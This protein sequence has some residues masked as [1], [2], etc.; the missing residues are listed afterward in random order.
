LETKQDLSSITDKTRKI[1]WGRSGNRCAI[2]K[3][4]LIIGA[5][6]KDSEAIVGDECHIV[7]H[8]LNGPRFDPTYPNDKLDSYDNLILLCRVHHKMIDDQSIAYTAD[9]LHQMKNDHEVM[10][11]DKL[12]DKQKIKPL[13][14][15]RIKKNIPNYL[16]RLTTGRQIIDIISGTY[17]FSI[18]HD[19]LISQDEVDIV[20]SFLQEVSDC[21]DLFDDL[22]PNARVNFAF[23]F[24]QMLNELEGKGFVAFGG[25]EVQL[26]EG[27]NQDEPSKWP[28]A[29]VHVL[30]NDN[31]AIIRPSKE[32]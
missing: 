27:G 26:L 15:L 31:P 13:K 10:I 23:T 3:H 30:R 4:E 17:A 32:N 18:D 8:E 22:E 9:I 20:G 7:S 28:I 11:S 6:V 14:F 12:S 5:T 1:L 2:C 24:T 19:E 25:R 21:V 29:I 16:I